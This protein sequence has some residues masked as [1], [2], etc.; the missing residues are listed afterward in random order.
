MDFSFAS[1]GGGGREND[2]RRERVSLCS[3]PA[4]GKIFAIAT[5]ITAQK[6]TSNG[7]LPTLTGFT[8]S[9]QTP[10]TGFTR[11]SYVFVIRNAKGNP[12][13]RSTREMGLAEK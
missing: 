4:S 2:K 11:N 13:R 5:L 12:M 1:D 9:F 3:P 8:V 6:L 10:G 7:S